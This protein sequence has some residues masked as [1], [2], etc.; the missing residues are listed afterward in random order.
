M[1]VAIVHDWLTGM[2]GGERCLEVFCELFPQAHLYTLLHLRGSLSP[3][4]ERMRIR[5]SFVQHLPDAARGYRRYLPLFPAAVGRFDLS[6]Y[7][8][9]LS[10]SHCVA[11]GAR[12]RVGVPHVCYCYTPMRYIWDLYDD[13]FGPG[14]GL[15]GGRLSRWAVGLAARPL[16]RWD[17][18]SS[19]RVSHFIASSQHVANR[20]R[21]HYGRDSAVIPPPVDCSRFPPPTRHWKEGKYYLVLGALVPYKRVALA[22]AAAPHL[23]YPLW[24]VGAGPEERRL[25]RTAG[26]RVRF[27]GRRPDHETPSIYAGCRALLFPGEEDFG[28]VPL[29]AMA[30]GRPVVAYAKGGAV[31]T[32][33]GPG[34]MD[35]PGAGVLFSRPTV[36]SLLA[37]VEELESGAG[38][39]HPEALREQ[40]SRFDRAL[41]KSRIRSYIFGHVLSRGEGGGE[42]P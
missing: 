20:I 14:S 31:E 21:R 23:R 9:V 41:F 10:S 16:R 25:R 12:P 24:V 17:V 18:R 42:G 6:S 33:V 28:I 22:V 15:P 38:Q 36:E 32:V 1:K 2:R 40:A 19:D 30:S 4:L 13:Y 3:T 34:R 39:W 35:S 37:A 26:P 8:F 7:D 5:T 27:L 11:K 29:E